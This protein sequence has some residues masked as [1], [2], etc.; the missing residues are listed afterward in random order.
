M[1]SFS[2]GLFQKSEKNK[3]NI[4]KMNSVPRCKDVNTELLTILNNKALKNEECYVNANFQ[5]ML[6]IIKMAHFYY[7][8][9]KIIGTHIKEKEV[10]ISLLN[11]SLSPLLL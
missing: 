9:T 6:H 1:K 10:N 2:V 4:Q 7:T 8:N 3:K 5:K 11:K